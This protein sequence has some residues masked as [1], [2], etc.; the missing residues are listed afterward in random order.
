VGVLRLH[1]GVCAAAV[2]GG[3]EPALL[4]PSK[5]ECCYFRLRVLLV[6][7]CLAVLAQQAV[8]SGCFLFKI[9]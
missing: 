7:H 3:P 9:I 5:S 6:R 8:L 4:V 2:W 1:Q